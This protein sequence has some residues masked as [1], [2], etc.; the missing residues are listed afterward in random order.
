[1]PHDTT[2]KSASQKK[3]KVHQAVG[4]QAIWAEAKQNGNKTERN[5]ERKTLQGN[6][7]VQF[8]TRS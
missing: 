1:M 5:G 3:K 2:V 4:F 6:D 8:K 7:R